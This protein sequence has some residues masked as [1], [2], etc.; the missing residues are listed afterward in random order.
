M[1]DKDKKNITEEVNLL[2]NIK[3]NN[4][5]RYENYV[6]DKADANLYVVMEYCSGESLEDYLQLNRENRT[7]LEEKAIW[8]IFSEVV[9]AVNEIHN[10]PQGAI[11]HRDIMPQNILLD[12]N[13]TVKLTNFSLLR[14]LNP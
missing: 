5:V 2:R 11:L 1:S 9:S 4:I 12:K 10:D 14:R 13:N 3:S 6:V 8:K 7:L